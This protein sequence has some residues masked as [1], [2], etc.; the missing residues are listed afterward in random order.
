ME[1]RYRKKRGDRLAWL[2][3]L[4][5]VAISVGIGFFV[6]RK[7]L[8]PPAPL[9]RLPLAAAS[10][11][12][13]AVSATPVVSRTPL[14]ELDASDAF[15]RNLVAA[16]SANPAWATWLATDGLV[17]RFVV[18]VDNVAEGVSPTKQVP[19]L[20]P[21]GKFNI[22][23]R[24]QSVF[25]DPKSYRRYDLVANV[26][27]SLDPKGTVEAYRRLK[28]LVDHAYSELGYPDRKFDVT[29]AKAIDR[30]LETP[31]PGGEVA[32]RPGLRSYKLADPELEAATPAQKQFMRLGPENMTKIKK[33]LRELR[34]ALALPP[35][36][37]ER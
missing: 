34:E 7:N 8:A 33:K 31:V 13:P 1:Q 24:G 25:V 10:P 2:L 20:A 29:L 3:I 27:E 28:P 6:Y 11:A 17:R 37:K 9:P 14:P 21:K 18:V 4:F 12:A 19:F 36:P 16:L 26:I 23:E 32:L 35:P 5:V 30:L 15:V 22:V